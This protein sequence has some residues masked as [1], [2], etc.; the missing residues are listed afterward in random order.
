MTKKL[1]NNPFLYFAI[2]I[3]FCCNSFAQKNNFSFDHLDLH[4]GLAQSSINCVMQDD[5]G[6]MWFGTQDGLHK[7]DG[8]EFEIFKHVNKDSAS[9]SD[10][11]IHALVQDK[12]GTIW[13][14]TDQGLNTFNPIKIAFHE[15]MA[16]ANSLKKRSK[17]QI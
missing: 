12:N 11:N 9:I 4:D 3:I 2:I 15:W 14:A 1:L 13:I 10:N 16:I 6:F 8:Y 17:F 5:K 7:Y